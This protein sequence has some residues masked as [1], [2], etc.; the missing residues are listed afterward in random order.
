MTV[1]QHT[2]KC[3]V[4]CLIPDADYNS[5]MEGNSISYVREHLDEEGPDLLIRALKR[6]GIDCDNEDTMNLLEALQRV[7][8]AE[9]PSNWSA[10]LEDVAVTYK[11]NNAAALQ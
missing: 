9:E 5:D 2:T 11:L 1:N 3:A 7:H 6:N 4:G 8:D 10:A